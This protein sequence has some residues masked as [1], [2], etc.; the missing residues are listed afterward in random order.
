MQVVKCATDALMQQNN[1][2]SYFPLWEFWFPQCVS[3]HMWAL[4][5]D[6]LNQIFAS[7]WSTLASGHLLLSALHHCLISARLQLAWLE[8][9][10][11]RVPSWDLILTC[12]SANV[13]E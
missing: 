1:L 13:S 8:T 4:F 10:G 6:S 12:H 7:M 5:Q 2:L 11:L 3:D 9:Y